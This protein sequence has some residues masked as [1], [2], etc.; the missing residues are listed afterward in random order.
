MVGI[1]ETGGGSGGVGGGGGGL[2]PLEKSFWAVLLQLS[3]A[4][5]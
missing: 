3:R 2:D 4:A 1:P 5:A